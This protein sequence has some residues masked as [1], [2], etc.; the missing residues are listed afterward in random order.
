MK[1]LVLR[2][3]RSALWSWLWRLLRNEH[4]VTLL[5]A[6]AIGVA[7]A[8][9][10]IA[11]RAMIL[12]GQRAF[13]G[14]WEYSLAGLELRPWYL[15][16]PLPVL[17]GLLLGPLLRWVPEIRG[18][19]IPEVIEAVSRRGGRV[20]KRVTPL[21]ALAAA[22]TIGSGGSAG[23]E[24][25]I[26]HIGAAL[27]STLAQLLHSPV[28]HARTFVGCGAAAGIAATFNTPF[29]GVLFATEVIL[30]DFQ[31]SRFSAIVVSS[32]VATL[33]S[34]N[35][36]GDFAA[37]QVPG[38]ELVSAWELIPYLF[39]GVLSALIGAGFT[40]SL[41]LGWKFFGALKQVPEWL[42]PAM[43]GLVVGLLAVA[44]PHVM[45][46]GYETINA[47][48]AGE[49]GLGLALAVLAAKLLATAASLSSGGSG[50]VF[51]P[52]L[53]LGALL[54]NSVGI[55]MGELAP[56]LTAPPQAYAL[57][58]M[59]AMVAATTRAPISAVL[60]IFEMSNRFEVILPLMLACVPATLLGTALLRH[61]VYT[62]KLAARGVDV[63]QHRE[64]NLLK[65]VHVRDVIDLEAAVLPRGGPLHDVLDLFLH[66]NHSIAF[67]NDRDGHPR[68]YIQDQDLRWV[69]EDRDNLEGVVVAGDL[70][71][72]CPALLHVDDELSVA[73]RVLT[74][75]EL[76]MLPVI[77][78]EGS[79][80]GAV[81]HGDV[82]QAYL[83]ELSNR[84][85]QGSAAEAITLTDRMGAADLGGGAAL[86]Q[87]EVPSHLCGRSLAELDLRQ[88]FG[89]QVVLILRHRDQA[90]AERIVPGASD[91]LEAGD[92]M[93]LLGSEAC[94][95]KATR[96]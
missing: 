87:V 30:R 24:G 38:F 14:T 11:F 27:G 85:A 22:I 28:I 84:D 50:G 9:G 94:I 25:P 63:S 49:I 55:L 74:Q 6:A 66:T 36:I 47:C 78:N 76:E 19:G 57:V 32:V 71:H 10:A 90:D 79:Y 5:A 53:V 52:S 61:S 43:G 12:L 56:T 51:A 44:L 45:G 16:L 23:R 77:N 31:M 37:I 67:V 75:C 60:M 48:L 29:A 41:G 26:V 33:V 86:M 92:A 17:G 72:P 42:H 68:G 15:L 80:V 91:V 35:F 7:G 13:F 62:A 65:G 39:I 89:V 81:G 46:V 3:I 34:H 93:L 58:A 64:L 88:R 69:L 83:H 73:T 95:Q 70:A 4:T 82:L 54:G 59:G 96:L 40:R 21:K 1:A 2:W 18:S 20:R 8:A